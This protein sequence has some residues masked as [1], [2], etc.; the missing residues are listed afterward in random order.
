[1][2]QDVARVGAARGI[3]P[4]RRAAHLCLRRP[5]VDKAARA[6]LARLVRDCEASSGKGGGLLTWGEDVEV[7]L[8]GLTVRGCISAYNGGCLAM[9]NSLVSLIDVSLEECKSS[10]HGYLNVGRIAR[11]ADGGDPVSRV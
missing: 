9:R 7:R 2:W 8:S 6:A 5:C 3:G 10:K 1:M 4:R 11:L